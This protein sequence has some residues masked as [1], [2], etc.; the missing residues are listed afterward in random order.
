MSKLSEALRARGIYNDHSLLVKF[1]TKGKDVALDYHAPS[2]AEPASGT[3]A[4]SPSHKTDPKASWYNHGC[5][6]FIGYKAETL[7]LAQAWATKRYRI[8]EW[9]PSPFSASTLVRA[10]V[11]AAAEKFVRDTEPK[12]PEEK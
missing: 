1:G 12:K 2:H 7:P 3:K 8:R 6:M 10:Y 9:S 5:K 4:Y 11:R